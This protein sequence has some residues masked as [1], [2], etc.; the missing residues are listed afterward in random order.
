MA[1]TGASLDLPRTMYYSTWSQLMMHPILMVSSAD[2]PPS[3]M[4]TAA[5]FHL[6]LACCLHPT[7]VLVVCHGCP[8]HQGPLACYPIPTVQWAGPCCQTGSI[9]LF[10]HSPEGQDLPIR[11]QSLAWGD[12]DGCC[13][14]CPS[15]WRQRPHLLG[16]TDR[17]RT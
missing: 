15:C 14:C 8:I 13:C 9:L 4:M 2:Q 5:D 12:L 11:S 10:Q 16:P 6:Q 7:Q 17:Q 1:A 3:P